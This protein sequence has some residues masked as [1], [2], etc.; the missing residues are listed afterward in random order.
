VS[1]LTFRS[2]RPS[3]LDELLRVEKATWPPD[4]QFT[5]SNFESQLRVFPEGIIC[6][7]APEMIGMFVV[8]RLDYDSLTATDWYSICDDGDF[9]K[10][11]DPD[12]PD[13]YGVSMSV[14]AEARGKGFGSAIVREVIERSRAWGARRF[15]VGARMPWYHEHTDMPPEDYVREGKDPQVE[16]YR[17][18]GV[19]VIKVLPDYF[20]DPD[21]LD[22][23]VLM[24]VTFT[25]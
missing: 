4:Q 17:R 18:G 20:R 25:D 11:F 23:G 10:T 6:G 21:S 16:Y 1:E 13:V 12:G 22:F 24:G 14:A 15:L 19:E 5:R 3:D 8:T 2:A 9:E 7:F